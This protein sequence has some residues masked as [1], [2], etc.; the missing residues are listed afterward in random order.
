MAQ[1]LVLELDHD[2]RASLAAALEMEGHGVLL[3]ADAARCLGLLEESTVPVVAVCGNEDPANA[4]LQ[5]FFATVAAHTLLA[6]RH[7]Y[8]Y[9]TTTP[10]TIPPG[11]SAALSHLAAPI[12]AKPFALDE[13][14]AAVGQAASGL[15]PISWR[16]GSVR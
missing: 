14:L 4:G 16:G 9:L 13:L 5:R 1:V 15:A 7:R 11:L 2:V 10:E 3:A 8:V 6:K 12:L